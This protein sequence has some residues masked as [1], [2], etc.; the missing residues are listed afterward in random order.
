MTTGRINQVTFSFDQDGKKT[1]HLVL[2]ILSTKQIIDKLS[3]EFV[4]QKKVETFPQLS[5]KRFTCS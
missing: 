3:K 4:T 1:P 5:E 2:P